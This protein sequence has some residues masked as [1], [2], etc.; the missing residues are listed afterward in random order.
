MAILDDLLLLFL[1]PPEK[2]L[3][4]LLDC[5]EELAQISGYQINRNKYEAV[6]ILI[7]VY[8]LILIS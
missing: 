1:T 4:I 2:S 6:S 8:P 5:I 7:I 3:L